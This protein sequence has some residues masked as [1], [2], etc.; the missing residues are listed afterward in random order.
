MVYGPIFSQNSKLDEQ[1]MQGLQTIEWMK[2]KKLK[3]YICSTLNE[4]THIY[5]VTLNPL[6]HLVTLAMSLACPYFN[7]TFQKH[8]YE[9]FAHVNNF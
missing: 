7:M 3:N 2:Q 4:N 6:T 5:Y 9:D 1:L 8:P